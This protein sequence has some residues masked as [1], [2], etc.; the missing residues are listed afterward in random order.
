MP[1]MLPPAPRKSAAEAS[2]TN[3]MSRVY[4]MRSCPC[5]SFQKLRKNVMCSLLSFRFADLRDPEITCL[6]FRDLA[7]TA[8]S[9]TG[10]DG[11]WCLS[12]LGGPE[13]HG[14]AVVID[15]VPARGLFQRAGERRA[16]RH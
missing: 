15:N 2:A 16:G 4:S 5:S 10:S 8:C 12:G 7:I 11:N 9:V 1:L 14:D 6:C 3:A 13:D